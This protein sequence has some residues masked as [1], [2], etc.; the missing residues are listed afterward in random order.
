MIR[1][2]V[3]VAS[4][5]RLIRRATYIVCGVTAR[6]LGVLPDA[7]LAEHDHVFVTRAT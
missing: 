6:A 3:L 7:L 4:S 2:L 5:A 1:V